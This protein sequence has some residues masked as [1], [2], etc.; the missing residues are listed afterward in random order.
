MQYCH[1]Q[2]KSSHVYGQ[3]SSPRGFQP[4]SRVSINGSRSYRRSCDHRYLFFLLRK[5][6][7]GRKV[8][9]CESKELDLRDVASIIGRCDYS[10]RHRLDLG[11]K[12]PSSGMFCRITESLHSI[13]SFSTVTPWDDFV[14]F[15]HLQRG[16]VKKEK[17]KRKRRDRTLLLATPYNPRMP[18]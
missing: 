18:N 15:A 12:V 5:W 13:S 1:S 16:S 10:Y 7:L 3:E 17:R 9:W 8:I 2:E 11:Y 14:C 6:A 4:S